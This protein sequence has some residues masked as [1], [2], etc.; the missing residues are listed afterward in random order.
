MCGSSERWDL[1]PI[2]FYIRL[3]CKTKLDFN[4]QIYDNVEWWLAFFFSILVRECLN[5]LSSAK[6]VKLEILN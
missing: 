3:R 6:H 4:L 2:R 5:G 1:V